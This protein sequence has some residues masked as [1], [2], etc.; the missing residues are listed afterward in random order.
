MGQYC[1]TPNYDDKYS[2]SL[3]STVAK[4]LTLRKSHTNR[5]KQDVTL[6][7]QQSDKF[8]SFK[9]QVPIYLIYQA[10]ISE[11]EDLFELKERNEDE[12]SII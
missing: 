12:N 1:N 2:M 4:K 11:E 8:E 5:N 7:K 6:A 3:A 9:D 10:I